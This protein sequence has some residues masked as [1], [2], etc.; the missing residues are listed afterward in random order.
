[1]LATDRIKILIKE[2]R[3]SGKLISKPS[4][5]DGNTIINT[6]F[7]PSGK[8]RFKLNITNGRLHSQ[9][10]FYYEDGQVESQLKRSSEIGITDWKGNFS[11]SALRN[12]SLISLAKRQS[13]TT[14]P[15]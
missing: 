13:T 12:I 5:L 4:P 15:L 10:T 3:K 2:Y 14:W 7:Y 8:R 6:G 11:S 9:G 1:M